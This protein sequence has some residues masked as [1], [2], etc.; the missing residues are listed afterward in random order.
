MS[1]D[2]GVVV[3]TLVVER[4]I[5]T[6]SDRIRVAQGTNGEIIVYIPPIVPFNVSVL[7]KDVITVV[8]PREAPIE[9]EAPKTEL[10]VS[11]KNAPEFNVDVTVGDIPGPKGDPGTIWYSGS[12]VPSNTLGRDGDFYLNADN[13]NVYHKVGGSWA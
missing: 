13:G 2:N 7:K 1:L 11:V 9:V 5:D 10:V 12:G 6:S 8:I 4:V 3:T